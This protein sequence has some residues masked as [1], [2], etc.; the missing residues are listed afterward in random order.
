MAMSEHPSASERPHDPAGATSAE[1][2]QSTLSAAIVGPH[3]QIQAMMSAAMQDSQIFSDPRRQ[4][5]LTDTF[6]ATL[7][8]HLAAVE[9]A[10][11]PEVRKRIPDG[12]TLAAQQ[13]HLARQM[14]LIMRMIEGSFY[15]DAYAIAV[16][17]V[18]LWEEMAAQLDDHVVAEREIIGRMDEILDGE[19]Q[20]ALRE[21]FVKAV[22]RAPTRPHP[23]S[24]H[25]AVL[26]RLS[27]RLWAMADRAMDTMDGRIIP[28]QPHKVH[29]S[30]DSL[31][32]QYLL[33]HEV[34][35]PRERPADPADTTD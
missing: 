8:R 29:G 9:D 11:Y 15:G 10:V 25:S 17:R 30:P 18:V 5:A 4:F 28:T 16:P 20:E 26:G 19:Q 2:A 27:H 31:L 24:P 35:H 34:E 22:E 12:K 32:T 33:G 1:S 6:L 13:I 14:E 7:S 3:D 23:Y 21:S